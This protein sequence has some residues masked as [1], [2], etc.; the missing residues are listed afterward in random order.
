MERIVILR[1]GPPRTE[2][3]LDGC[4]RSFNRVTKDLGYKPLLE[5]ISVIKSVPARMFGVDGQGAQSLQVHNP[6]QGAHHYLYKLRHLNRSAH[7][8]LIISS[9]PKD[10]KRC[11]KPVVLRVYELDGRELREEDVI[12]I[13][14]EYL[15][16]TRLNFWNLETGASRLA[17]PVKMAHILSYMKASGI[18]VRGGH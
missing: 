17:L 18:P 8:V 5:Y 14:E 15:S 13:A 11:T 1:D 12:K 6:L 3:E 4:L 7:E 2:D 10:E 16:L 9:R